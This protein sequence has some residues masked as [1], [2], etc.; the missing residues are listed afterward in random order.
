[1]STVGPSTSNSPYAQVQAL[2]KKG[3][4]QGS[5]ASGDAP[6]QTF[7]A[8]STQGAGAPAS[9]AAGASSGKTSTSGGTFPRFEPQTLQTL[10]A[11]QTSDR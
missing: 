6:S 9:T 5:A 8:T 7:S 4:S 2:W 10:L 1:M 11:L 3:Q